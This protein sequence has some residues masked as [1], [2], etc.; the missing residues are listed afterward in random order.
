[1]E[2]LLVHSQGEVFLAF[3]ACFW[4]TMRHRLSR[5]SLNVCLESLKANPS[6][7]GSLRGHIDFW[8]AINC[9]GRTLSILEHGYELPFLEE[10]P[11]V[12]LG[13]NK[14]SVEHADFVGTEIA[15]L[16]AK[17]CIEEVQDIPYFVS[18]L[19]VAVQQSSGKKRLILDLSMLNAYIAYFKFKLE[20]IK[21]LKN[22]LSPDSYLMTFDLRSGY[23]HVDIHPKYFKY[24]GFSWIF[25]GKR[26]FF[27]FRV[28]CFGLS[29]APFVFTKILRNLVLHWRSMGIKVIIYIDDGVIVVKT[30]FQQ[31]KMIGGTVR[32]D[33]YSAGWFE[34]EEKCNWEPRK[35]AEWLGIIID[36]IKFQLVIPPRRI[37]SCLRN[38]SLFLTSSS[39]PTVR[40]I[41]KLT[42]K[43]I[44]MAQVL[45]PI[46]QLQTR[47]L[48]DC[49]LNRASWDSFA[50]L[51]TEQFVE[52]SFWQTNLHQVNVF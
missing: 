33:L 3:F 52:L 26:R 1:M 48:Y 38:I 46:A 30:S 45:G 25:D 41:S 19:S 27:V 5:P 49:I 35:I 43:L 37:E 10:P 16:L 7:Q 22:Y 32:R 14:S 20:D 21:T 12:H 51:G 34:A 4:V 17:G 39:A 6:V 24:L 18:P 13:N 28:L 36:L 8:K 42:G 50:S 47:S 29:A 9:D 31:A 44:S 15:N 11:S 40:D 23:H 2:D